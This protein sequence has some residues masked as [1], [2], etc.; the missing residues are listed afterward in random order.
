M[1]QPP[2]IQAPG[3]FAPV[4]AFGIEDEDGN[5]SVVSGIRPL[6]TRL[7]PADVPAA[8]VG[9]TSTSTLVGPFEPALNAAVYCTI[10]GDFDGS[11]Q[12]ARSTDGGETLH[13]LT[14]AGSQWGAFFGPACEPVW[15]ESEEGASLWLDCKISS[16]SLEY[17]VSQ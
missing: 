13:P 15:Q 4:V 1:S 16:G 2:P 7:A 14:V 8:L 17:R 3:G 10:S 11:V 5:C 9:T 6:P 12:V